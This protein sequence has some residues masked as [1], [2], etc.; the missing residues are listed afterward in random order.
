[1]DIER[2][3]AIGPQYYKLEIPALLKQ[4]LVNESYSSFLDCGCGDGSLINALVTGGYLDGKEVHAID[5]SINRIDLVRQISKSITANVDSAEILSTVRDESI[6]FLVSTQ[7]IE[8]VDQDRM[9]SAISKVTKKGSTIYLSTVY[10]KEYGWYFH[11]NKVGKWVIDPT[12]IIEYEKDNELFDSID[13]SKFEILENMKT[14]LSFPLT[15]FFVKRM[16]IKN[17]SLY[18]NRI[19]K[20]LRNIEVPIPGYYN[21]EIV[22]RRL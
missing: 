19:L 12:H 2:Y 16:R 11:K 8:H 9:L 22:L 1:M 17:R 10:K 5:L 13:R 18:N 7:V 20:I 21:W 4:Y 15:D 6:D 14:Q 3:S